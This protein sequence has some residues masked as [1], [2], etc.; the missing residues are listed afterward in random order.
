[1]SQI[2]V[3]AN[4]FGSDDKSAQV[5]FFLDD[6]GMIFGEGSGVGGVDETEEI[7]VVD[8]IVVAVPL[9][10]VFDGEK[11][12]GLAGRVE[13]H[14]GVENKLMFRAVEVVGVDNG[15][16]FW[17]DITLVHEHGR[18]QLLLHIDSVGEV[19]MVKHD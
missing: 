10:F 3:L 14:N 18:E 2:S 4:D 5:G 9:Q 12:D 17:N 6:F 15:E 13:A 11:I 8:F 1:M 19:V 16:N 7:D